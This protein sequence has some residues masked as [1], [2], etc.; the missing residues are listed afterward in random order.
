MRV[1]PLAE[2]REH[3]DRRAAVGERLLQTLTAAR[4]HQEAILALVQGLC[5]SGAVTAAE[6]LRGEPDGDGPSLVLGVCGELHGPV[7]A[8]DGHGDLVLR[9]TGAAV[10]DTTLEVALQACAATLDRLDAHDALRR[11]ARTDPLTGLR[12]RR[13]F[14]ERLRDDLSRAQREHTPLALALVDVDDLKLVNDELGHLGGDL[15]LTRVARL[16]ETCA[17]T[18]DLV[19]RIGGDEF[20]LL[21]P[22]TDEEGARTLVERLQQEVALDTAEPRVSLSV[23]FTTSSTAGPT[24]DDLVAAADIALYAA[25]A[26]GKGCNVGP[27]RG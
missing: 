15:L 14:R 10:P 3:P 12:N 11:D 22:T 13:S 8:Y 17:R 25:K 21:L 26:A 27:G 7:H 16:L 2:S 19:A 4:T 6:L 23:G 24:A 18:H 5:R 1:P 20:A 9:V